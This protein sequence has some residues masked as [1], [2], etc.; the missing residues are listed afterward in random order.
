MKI[1]IANRE[2][3]SK[4][5]CYKTLMGELNL[6]SEKGEIEMKPDDATFEFYKALVNRDISNKDFDIE[7]IKV[8]QG[9]IYFKPVDRPFYRLYLRK[10][11]F[12]PKL[13]VGIK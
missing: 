2:F 1:K 9:K 13:K 3:K 5:C 4:G 6:M 8:K 10:V 7:L 12:L 11:I